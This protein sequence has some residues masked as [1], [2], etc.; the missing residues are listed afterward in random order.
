MTQSELQIHQTCPHCG[1][2]LPRVTDVFCPACHEP[3]SPPDASPADLPPSP[4]AR[5][6]WAALLENRTRPPTVGRLFL[7]TAWASLALIVLTGAG[8]ALMR[9]RGEETTAWFP[10][11]PAA[12][13]LLRDVGLYVR[14]A[15]GWA[16]QSAVMDWERIERL[17]KGDARERTQA[18]KAIG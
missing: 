11:G 9:S 13:A 4:L 3:L 14:I 1:Y 18:D 10:T 16:A 6:V 7:K 15:R 8:V 5:E 17:A 12:G 2:G